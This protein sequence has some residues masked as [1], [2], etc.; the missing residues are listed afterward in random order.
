MKKKPKIAVVT[1]NSFI[2]Y[3]LYKKYK[4]L[5]SINLDI[6]LPEE[7]ANININEM[8]DE[9][10]CELLEKYNIKTSQPAIGVVEET[11]DKL[12]KSYDYLI[13]IG[14][15]QYVSATYSIQYQ[16]LQLEKF[17]EKIIL[18]DSLAMSTILEELI[19][20]TLEFIETYEF[21]N[22]TDLK[23]KIQNKIY[24]LINNNVCL[25]F[26]KSLNIIQRGGRISKLS[27]KVTNLLKIHPILQFKKGN[28]HKY[29]V[30]TNYF[31]GIIKTITSIKNKL[32]TNYIEIGYS[33]YDDK[34]FI[35]NLKTEFTNI[36]FKQ[37]KDAKISKLIL[38]HWGKN[39][40]V[41]CLWRNKKI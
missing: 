32:N 4:N 22:I 14:I 16:L 10:Y 1:D 2:N 21:I 8:S 9:E 6:I 27:Y 40:L 20:K 11:W 26:P 23:N 5:K 36:G 33:K 12:L 37:I 29:S 28:F 39:F 25:L 18:I 34:N 7:I 13:I 35:P 15:S 41:V 17:K 19:I 24:E 3:D 31:K 30:M 38:T